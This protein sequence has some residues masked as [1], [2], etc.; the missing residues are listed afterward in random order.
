MC[1]YSKGE[2][3]QQRLS[4]SDQYQKEVTCVVLKHKHG[5]KSLEELVKTNWQAPPCQSFSFC[6]SGLMP[7][8]LHFNKFPNI[9]AAAGPGT[10]SWEPLQY[11]WQSSK[12]PNCLN[13]EG[14][15]SI[16]EKQRG[17]SYPTGLLWELNYLIYAKDLN[18]D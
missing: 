17:L 8:S 14:L 13:F 10:T 2:S 18:G 5:S 3:Q 7:K 1:I 6:K 15:T 12:L 16:S 9:A 4:F 11:S